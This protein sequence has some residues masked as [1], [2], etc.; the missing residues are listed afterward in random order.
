[1]DFK[2]I[3]KRLL[4]VPV[5]IIIILCILSAAAL[6]WVFVGRRDTEPVAYVIYIFAFYFSYSLFF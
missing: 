2:K 5:W 3:G 1:M 4:F 6:I